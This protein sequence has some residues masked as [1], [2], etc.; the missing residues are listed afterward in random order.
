M[1]KLYAAPRTRSI[2]IAWLLAELKQD[3]EL[4]LGTFKPTPSTLFIQDTP[5]G[6]YPTLDDNGLVL[7]ESDAI[8]EYLL[9]KFDNQLMPP[10]GT[11]QKAITLQWLHYADATAFSPLGMVIW[12]SRYRQDI[13]EHPGLINDARAR[14]VTGLVPISK[15]LTTF[16][17]IAGNDFS[18]ADIMMGFTVLAADMLGLIEADSPV[19]DYIQRITARDAFKAAALRLGEQL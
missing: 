10:P 4:I 17:W 11:A 6:K 7:M 13:H 14:A 16:P 12:L 18:A 1:I 3:Y 2:R 19:K 8:V 9:E 5:T 15:Q